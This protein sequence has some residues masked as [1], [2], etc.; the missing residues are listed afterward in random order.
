MIDDIYIAGFTVA[1]SIAA[2]LLTYVFAKKTSESVSQQVSA[3]SAR[4]DAAC[5]EREDMLVSLKQVKA[6]LDRKITRNAMQS[7]VRQAKDLTS[8]VI[9]RS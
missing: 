8:A 4:V 2:A 3:L 9:E 1:V 5:K 6:G 7:I